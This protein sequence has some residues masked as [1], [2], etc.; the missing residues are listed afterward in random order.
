M[1]NGLPTKTLSCV[2]TASG[3]FSCLLGEFPDL[4]RPTF[5]TTE[6]L[7]GALK[8]KAPN[9]AIDWS[10]DMT[11]AYTDTKQALGNT[12]ML[13]YPLPGAPI[14]LTANAPDY[15]IVVGGVWQP[16]PVIPGS[17]RRRVSDTIHGLLHPGRNPLQQ[18]VVARFV[19]H[20]LWKDSGQRSIAMLRR[21][22][23]YL[24]SGSTMDLVGPLPPSRGFTYLFTMV[25]RTTRWPEAILLASMMTA[26]VVWVFIGTWVA[27]FS[28]P[29]DFSSDRGP[30]F[31]SELWSKVA[32][33]LG[34][35]LHCTLH[36]TSC[37]P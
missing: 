33:S 2:L 16:H 4:T 26:D 31:T 15:A 9:H 17:W 24:R 29:S 18:L 10:A 14:A 35:T 3:E 34:M 8:S 25:D 28:V 30:H 19:W 32:R 20:R 12:T 1:L 11:K 22:S 7:F 36:C 6:P 37:H 21:R 5:S 23:R 27:W 13:A